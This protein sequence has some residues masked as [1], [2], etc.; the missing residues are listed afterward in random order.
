MK[1][2][3]FII[4][5]KGDQCLRD[6]QITRHGDYLYYKNFD[7]TVDGKWGINKFKPL[8]VRPQK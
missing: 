6:E 7:R 3:S 1:M 2:D 5:Y 8:Q 4:T